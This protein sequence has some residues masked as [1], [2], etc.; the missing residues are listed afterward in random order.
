MTIK[1]WFSKRKFKKGVNA[2]TIEW[3]YALKRDGNGK[4]N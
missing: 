2:T 3:V 1:L 4:H